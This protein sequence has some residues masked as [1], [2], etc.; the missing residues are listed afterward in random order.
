[1]ALTNPIVYLSNCFQ[2]DGSGY[3]HFAYYPN[4][5]ASNNGELPAAVCNFTDYVYWE[6]PSGS[7]ITCNTP[8]AGAPFSGFDALIQQDAQS[9]A[10]FTFVGSAIKFGHGW[11][12]PSKCYK[13]NKR[14]L[15]TTDK[16]YCQA[17]YYCEFR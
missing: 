17:I 10:D 15:Y 1:M 6:Q 5:S 8:S 4:E 9:L 12:V 3:S 16:G 2:N 7:Q 13:D 14:T 11:T